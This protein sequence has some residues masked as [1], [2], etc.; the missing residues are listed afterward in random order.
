MS[1]GKV[2]PARFSGGVVNEGE[3]EMGLLS[4]M[5]LLPPL[6]VFTIFV[7]GEVRVLEVLVRFL[8]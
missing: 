7:A 8:E 4:L 2:F 5:F 3:D 1:S 6:P